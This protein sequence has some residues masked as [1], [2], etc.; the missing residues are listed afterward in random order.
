M[1]ALPASSP[2]NHLVELSD[3]E[4][5]GIS[6]GLV[7]VAFKM[8]IAEETNEFF[9]QEVSHAGRKSMRGFHRRR[10]SLFSFEFVGSFESMDHFH[11]FFSGFMRL[12]DR[13]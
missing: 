10:R 5:A 4:L 7:N 11:S 9:T 3:E 8:T 2:P 6:A 13:D 12:F 1:S